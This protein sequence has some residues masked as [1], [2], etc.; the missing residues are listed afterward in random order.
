MPNIP[1]DIS[2]ELRGCRS[3]LNPI[4]YAFHQI[5][6]KPATLKV[7]LKYQCIPNLSSKN[8]GNEKM[9]NRF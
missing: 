1:T 2:W 7:K 4:F 3:V 6:S 8:A 5:S 9:G